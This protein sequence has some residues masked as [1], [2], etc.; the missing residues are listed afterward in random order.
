MSERVRRR[1]RHSL[2]RSVLRFGLA[3]AVPYLGVLALLAALQTRLIYFPGDPPTA[4]P[5]DLGLAFEDLSLAAGSD[6]IHAWFVP[7]D[8]ARG[9][10]I[11]AHGNA[12]SMEHRLELIHSMHRLRLNVLA[13]DYRGYGRSTGSP[14]EAATYEDAEAA[15]TWVTRERGVDPARIV[16]WGRSLGGGVA[17]ELAHRKRSGLLIVESTF[18]SLVDAARH[19]YPWLP[20]SW[21]LRHRYESDRKI[22]EIDAPTLIAHAP[23][24]TIVPYRLGR[25]LFDAAREPKTWAELEGGHH[26]P[27]LDQP[28]ALAVVRDFLERHLGR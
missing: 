20:V 11:F 8:E 21:I 16:L 28:A 26:L 1:R 27:M 5:S 14:S 13:F 24:D 10:V 12:G 22:R 4:S 17:V 19:H 9:T 2:R 15:W 18:S 6:T 3:L 7:A 23:D 25:R